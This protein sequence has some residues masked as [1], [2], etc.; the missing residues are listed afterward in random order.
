MVGVA[1]GA[2]VVAVKVLDKNGSGSTTGVIGGIDY[3]AGNGAAGDVANMSLTGGAYL[4]LD[5][6]VIGASNNGIYFALAAGNDG[7]DAE[8]Y[9]P[10]R[11]EGT[12][13]YTVSAMD[14]NDNWAYFSNYGD[15]V[16]YCAPG[17]SVKSLTHDAPTATWS[18][19]S[20]AAPHVAGLLLVNGG[21]ISSDGFVNGDPDG[22]PDP[23]AHR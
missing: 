10:A 4:A 6:A 15:P 9:S 18:G 22:N 2:T 23:I 12:Y 19:T 17:V 5:Q 1:A 13:I 14:I 7:D 11:A 3:V 8:G 20:M 21:N 16:D